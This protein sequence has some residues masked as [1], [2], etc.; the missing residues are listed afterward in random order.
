MGIIG[1]DGLNALDLIG[2]AEAFATVQPMEANRSPK[3]AYEVVV[4]GL[5]RRRFVAE[6]GVLFHPQTTLQTAPALDTIIIPGG[7][8]LRRPDANLAVATW[9]KKRAPQTGESCRSA[10]EFTDW[11]RVACSM[12][13][14]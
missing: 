8:G 6:S 7:R 12:A 2:P 11:P 1:F 9:I 13:G 4:I 3:N 14:G 5:S 10:P